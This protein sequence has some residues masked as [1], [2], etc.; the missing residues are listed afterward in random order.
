MLK[1]WLELAVIEDAEMLAHT[2]TVIISMHNEAHA[3][4]ARYNNLVHNLSLAEPSFRRDMDGWIC[5]MRA[6][7]YNDRRPQPVVRS[8]S[9][10]VVRR[11]LQL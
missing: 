3:L 10:G 8:L 1:W 9:F 7:F 11:G 5:D 4:H 6:L 2:A